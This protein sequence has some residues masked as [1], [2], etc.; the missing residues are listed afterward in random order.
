VIIGRQ[1]RFAPQGRVQDAI[2]GYTNTLDLI[3]LDV[4]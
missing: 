2:F 3:A 4:L 1:C